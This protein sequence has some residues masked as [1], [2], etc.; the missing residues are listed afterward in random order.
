VDSI[1]A[2]KRSIEKAQ[3]KPATI[4]LKVKAMKSTVR[5]VA[6]LEGSMDSITAY[7]LNAALDD[8]RCTKV[9]TNAET[10]R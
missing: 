10:I 5:K 4:T 7:R 6:T 3:Y 2:F 8:I 9:Q 1:E